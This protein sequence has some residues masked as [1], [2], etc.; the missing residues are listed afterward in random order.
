MSPFRSFLDIWKDFNDIWQNSL[1]P[2]NVFVFFYFLFWITSN[3]HCLWNFL[4]GGYLFR[5]ILKISQK[6]SAILDFLIT[7]QTGYDINVWDPHSI[8]RWPW[9]DFKFYIKLVVDCYDIGIGNFG[10]KK[11]NQC[12]FQHFFPV[13]PANLSARNK[14]F[15]LKKTSEKDTVLFFSSRTG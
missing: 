13:N 4:I 6:I 3:Y 10:I 2:E 14:S 1:S 12:L 5:F 7:Y 9:H 15:S 11:S 8:V